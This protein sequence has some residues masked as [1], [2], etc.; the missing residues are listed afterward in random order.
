MFSPLAFSTAAMG[1]G[2]LWGASWRRA[3]AF[4]TANAVITSGGA[5]CPIKATAAM[6]GGGT[7]TQEQISTRGA[8]E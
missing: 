7:L 6:L 8:E 3:L 1:E 4:S 2:A 5:V